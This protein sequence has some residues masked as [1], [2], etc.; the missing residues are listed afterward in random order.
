MPADWSG[1]AGKVAAALNSIIESNERPA[2][3][4]RRL[5]RHIGQEGQVQHASIGQAGGAW[6][7]S[8]DA[9]NDLVE[10]LG[11]RSCEIALVISAA[12]TGDLSQT[13]P[14]ESDARAL[15]GGVRTSA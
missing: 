14:L 4:I 3:E 1:T 13:M 2:R 9:V 6:A 7:S 8:L 5:S 10:D 12:A 11:R 15:Q